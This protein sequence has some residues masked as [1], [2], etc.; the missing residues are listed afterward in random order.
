LFAIAV[1]AG[2]ER[3]SDADLAGSGYTAA[4][5]AADGGDRPFVTAQPAPEA[6]SARTW[7]LSHA[8]YAEAVRSFVGVTPD[9]S[10]FEVE[11]DNGIYPNMSGSG[12]VRAQLAQDYYDSADTLS[13]VLSEEQL[14]ALIAGRP[15]QPSEQ[16]AFVASAIRRAFRR[17]ATPD[18]LAAYG[19][20]F[21]L[22]LSTPDSDTAAPF[23]AVIRALLA[24]P[25]FLYRTEIGEDASQPKFKLTA[26]ELASLL[27]F[28]ALGS[29]PSE[30]LLAAADSGELSTD[31]SV[32]RHVAALL[33]SP[34]AAAQEQ[35]FLG[36]WLEIHDFD[37]LDKDAT[38]FPDFPAVRPLLRD[39]SQ[40]FL[41]Q[42]G[43]LTGSLASLMSTAIAPQGDLAAYYASDPSAGGSTG[44]RTGILGLGAVIAAHSRPNITSPTLRGLFVR[45]RL[46]CQEIH[47][48]PGGAPNI[49]DVLLSG[50][51]RTTREMYE[52][53][54]QNPACAG[55]HA[56]LDS[57]GFNFEE[58]D[59]TGRFRALENGQPIDATGALVDSDMSGATAN[60]PA[61]ASRLAQSEWVRECVARQ[62]FRFYF[63]AVEAD[64]G[65]P[66]VQA[67]RRAIA[68]GTF[69][70]AIAALLT[71]ASARE[72]V[73]P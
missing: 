62:A 57:V 72:R 6:L 2:C 7:R 49:V 20:I 60:Q 9:T 17:P 16:Q 55:C 56:L 5:S 24:S 19:E 68:S 63:G 33:D 58:F 3:A 53:H 25:Y 23:R 30:T 13:A 12:I 69:R 10:G 35:R 65:V 34:E 41:A 15:L 54:S 73:R 31:G 70:D 44:T 59:A 39:E 8:Q 45:D 50:M 52:Q 71:S 40:A 11:L 29:P 61:L 51:P 18:D 27:S 66:A 28:S 64:R 21:E 14:A 26:Y 42:A 48:P 36:Q 32:A 1:C 38:L 4:D 22:S 37:A 67:A 47:L 46:L 43:S